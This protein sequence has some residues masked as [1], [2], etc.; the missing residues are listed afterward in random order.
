MILIDLI[1]MQIILTD[2]QIRMDELITLYAR[3]RGPL[4][5]S[6]AR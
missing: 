1:D 2:M 4:P 5:E 6:L 3:Q